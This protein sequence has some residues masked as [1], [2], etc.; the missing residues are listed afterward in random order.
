MLEVDAG[1]ILAELSR[2]SLAGRTKVLQLLVQRFPQVLEKFQSFSPFFDCLRM[3]IESFSSTKALAPLQTLLNKHV[4]LH[5]LVESLKYSF[6]KVQIFEAWLERDRA[7]METF[8]EQTIPETDATA[9]LSVTAHPI[10]R[11]SDAIGFEDM[12]GEEGNS[13]NFNFEDFDKRKK[14]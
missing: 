11:D 12:L 14:K 6:E 2:N 3:I 8:F 5:F 4:H 1:T 10:G 7:T 13:F 9:P